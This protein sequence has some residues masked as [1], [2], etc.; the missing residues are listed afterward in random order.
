MASIGQAQEAEAKAMHAQLREFPPEVLKQIGFETKED[1]G[2]SELG[3]PLRVFNL[4]LDHIQAF[5]DD[6]D[7]NELLQP[8]NEVV[9][10]ILSDG[11]VKSAMS[12]RF[13]EGKWV[14]SS[15]GGTE[16]HLVEA[17]R[18]KHA[19]ATDRRFDEY[20][21]ARA[22]ALHQIFIGYREDGELFLIPAHEHDHAKEFR[23]G[24]ALPAARAI[25][26]LQPHAAK[27]TTALPEIKK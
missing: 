21:I 16:V 24:D 20:F 11:K 22:L 23:V 1:L 27:F 2:K 14:N 25:L 13:V 9:Y 12:L 8:T 15:L 19:R 17:V 3:I 7:P 26:M 4:R 5:K 6:G 18:G 10:P